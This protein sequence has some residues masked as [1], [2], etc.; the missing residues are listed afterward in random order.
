MIFK[1]ILSLMITFSINNIGTNLETS[2]L[3][4]GSYKNG[5]FFM[6][7]CYC[8]EWKEYDRN[9][10]FM[11]EIFVKICKNIFDYFYLIYML[12]AYWF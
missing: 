12:W 8:F 9:N 1:I 3:Y 10:I 11:S 5:L 7:L 6:W 4:N 2:S